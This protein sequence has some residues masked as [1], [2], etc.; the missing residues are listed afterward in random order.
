M[1]KEEEEDPQEVTLFR[2]SMKLRLKHII[3]IFIDSLIP[4]PAAMY[5]TFNFKVVKNSAI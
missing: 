4:I 5:T 2:L 3:K 1:N